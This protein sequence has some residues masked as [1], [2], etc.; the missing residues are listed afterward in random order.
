MCSQIGPELRYSRER[1]ASH[2]PNQQIDILHMWLY[3][4]THGQLHAQLLTKL[5]ALFL[6][7]Q[8]VSLGGGGLHFFAST[9]LQSFWSLVHAP[10]PTPFCRTSHSSSPP[11]LAF[12]LQKLKQVSNLPVWGT[13]SSWE[14]PGGRMCES[15]QENDADYVIYNL[16]PI[17]VV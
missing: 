11:D 3:M 10:P 14:Q 8:L 12:T 17:I 5:S 4:C 15:V 9:V 7:S 2:R 16:L 13:S 6:K 1:H